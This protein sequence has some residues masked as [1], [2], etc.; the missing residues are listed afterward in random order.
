L[1]IAGNQVP[2]IPFN[3]VVG[4][5]IVPPIQIGDIELKLGR[6]VFV[7]ELIVTTAVSKQF[8]DELTT[9]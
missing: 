3:E 2:V 4:K 7:A 5:V 9:Q 8:I 1:S 6:I